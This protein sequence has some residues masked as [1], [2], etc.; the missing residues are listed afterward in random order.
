M[1]QGQRDPQHNVEQLGLTCRGRVQIELQELP[2]EGFQDRFSVR[3]TF[4]VKALTA[5]GQGVADRKLGA[6][7]NDS[8][9]RG[10]NA[11]TNRITPHK[12]QS[13]TTLCLLQAKCTAIRTSI[14]SKHG[15]ER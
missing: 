6:H 2:I 8:P 15:V 12:L 5:A 4:R 14:A 13:R 1:F 9:Q 7:R 3:L 11:Q 10:L